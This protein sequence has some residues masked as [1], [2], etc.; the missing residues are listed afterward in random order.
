M[1]KISTGMFLPDSLIIHLS[2][3]VNNWKTCKN[4]TEEEKA[5]FLHEYIHYLQAISFPISL[6]YLCVSLQIVQLYLNKIALSKEK[7]VEIPINFA[8]LAD[9]DVNYSNLEIQKCLFDLHFNY[10]QNEIDTIIEITDVSI[11]TDNI[12]FDYITSICK[13][14]D[15][16]SLQKNMEYVSI[17]YLS[18]ECSNNE[19]V[20]DAHCIKESMAYMIEKEVFHSKLTPPDFPYNV[21]LYVCKKLYPAFSKKTW[22]IVALCEISLLF[23][24]PGV[25]FYQILIKMRDMSFLPTTKNDFI[26][27]I[28]QNIFDED[29]LLDPY[30]DILSELKKTIDTLYPSTSQIECINKTRIWL[31]DVLKNMH[32]LRNTDLLCITNIILVDSPLKYIKHLVAKLHIP[33]II[34]KDNIISNPQDK[35][36]IFSL[37]I[38]KSL[39]DLFEK[40]GNN[41]TPFQCSMYKI[42]QANNSPVFDETICSLH[43]WNNTKGPQKYTCLLGVYWILFSLTGKELY[44][45]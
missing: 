23:L 35:D 21:C 32:I 31:H 10:N 37:L 15:I 26:S 25:W 30:L 17:S 13:G 12:I 45:N 7:K 39:M 28:T 29:M 9:K 43:P 8:K 6:K 16:E 42:C 44:V 4:L 1:E 40:N 19:Y 20:L 5:A 18:C 3:P 36:Y 41:D 38:I 27:Y 14:N 2:F 33:P 11:K 24:N 22:R 34:D